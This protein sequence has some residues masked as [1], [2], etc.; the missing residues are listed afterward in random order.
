MKKLQS[1]ILVGLIS[2][3]AFA[4]EPSSPEQR[5]ARLELQVRVLQGQVQALRKGVTNSVA[6]PAAVASARAVKPPTK[7][8]LPKLPVSPK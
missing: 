3:G 2:F 4:A 5:L 6:T 8:T 1:T 7:P